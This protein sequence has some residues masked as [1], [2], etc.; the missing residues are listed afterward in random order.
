MSFLSNEEGRVN[1]AAPPYSN[2]QLHRCLAP[3]MRRAIERRIVSLETEQASAA[4]EFEALYERGD[5]ILAEMTDRQ[6]RLR[7]FREIMLNLWG[8]E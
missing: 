4:D 5:A 3:S 7:R 2:G 8:S 6:D 1:G